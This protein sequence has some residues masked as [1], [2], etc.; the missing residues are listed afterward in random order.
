MNSTSV[1]TLEQWGKIACFESKMI[2]ENI[3][4]Q[5]IGTCIM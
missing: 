5:C 1:N 2:K 3:C 4:I